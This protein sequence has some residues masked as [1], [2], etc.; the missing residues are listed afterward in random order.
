MNI[1]WII[2]AAVAGAAVVALCMRKRSRR[3]LAEK[4][5]FSADDAKFMRMAISI[6]EKKRSPTAIP[7][8]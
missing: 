4:R 3:T 6:A 1:W 7:E 8:M 5:D 2:A